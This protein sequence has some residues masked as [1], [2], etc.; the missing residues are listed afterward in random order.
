MRVQI[1][2]R[3]KHQAK[4]VSEQ[5]VSKRSLKISSALKRRVE[6]SLIEIVCATAFGFG[7]IHRQ[8]RAFEQRIAV[9]AV[10]RRYCDSNARAYQHAAPL[11]LHGLGYLLDDAPGKQ[12]RI[13]QMLQMARD[14]GE[15][16]AAEACDDVAFANTVDQDPACDFERG[17]TRGM[18]KLVVDV[19]EV[20]EVDAEDADLFTPL[21]AHLDVR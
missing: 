18:S 21:R 3:L 4:F 13:L 11:D 17:V 15:F 2:Q 16:V 10:Q 5:G 12:R 8:I 7:A 19:L 14:H 9:F 6:F 1:Q 20:I